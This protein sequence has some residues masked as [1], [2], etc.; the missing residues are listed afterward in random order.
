MELYVN[1]NFV[2]S[3]IV[4]TT[5]YTNYTTNATLSGKDQIDVYFANDCYAPPE[6]RNLFVDYVIVNG[7]THQAEGGE[8]LQ[9]RSYASGLLHWTNAAPGPMTSADACAAPA[10]P[11]AAAAHS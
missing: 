7:V 11:S 8:M 6:D 2:T 9:V 1:G 5:S 4:N 3:W 10:R